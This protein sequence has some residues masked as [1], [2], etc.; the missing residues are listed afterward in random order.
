MKNEEILEKVLERAV[1]NGY[2][3]FGMPR[4]FAIYSVIFSHGFAKAF[5]K[6]TEIPESE[7]CD[8]EKYNHTGEKLGMYLGGG[9]EGY[10]DR[11][12]FLGEPWQ[13]HLQQMVLEEDPIKY[14][15]QFISP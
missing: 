7:D 14:L 6:D 15:E 13:Y 12:I 3:D 2:P 10:G 5:F 9:Y 4:G 8:Y 11:C 1:K